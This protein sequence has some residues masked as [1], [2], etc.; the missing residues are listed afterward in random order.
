MACSLSLCIFV[1]ASL[2]LSLSNCACLCGRGASLNAVVG[3]PVGR[4]S[5]FGLRSRKS[6]RRDSRR[7]PNRRVK[8]SSR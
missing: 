2:S 5:G 8:P 6:L 3:S 7:I 1:S 4:A